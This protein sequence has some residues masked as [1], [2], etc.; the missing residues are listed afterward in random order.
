MQ[1]RGKCSQ[2]DSPSAM[3]APYGRQK[4]LAR[5]S[6]KSP[7]LPWSSSMVSHYVLNKIWT[8]NEGQPSRSCYPSSLISSL[9]VPHTLCSEASRTLSSSGTHQNL[10]CLRASRAGAPLFLDHPLSFLDFSLLPESPAT[11]HQWLLLSY[12]QDFSAASSSQRG[13]LMVSNAN[14]TLPGILSPWWQL[15]QVLILHSLRVLV[16]NMSLLPLDCELQEARAQFI[17]S[18]LIPRASHRGWRPKRKLTG[19]AP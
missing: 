18:L 3:H 5:A 9:F 17:C 1:A 7:L 15:F 16:F 12:P 4:A 19:R 2:M 6:V 14:S 8:F 13:L 10:S 11:S